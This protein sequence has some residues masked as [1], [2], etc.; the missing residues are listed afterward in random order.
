MDQAAVEPVSI[1]HLTQEAQVEPTEMLAEI[2]PDQT[3]PAV[4]EVAQVP[5][6]QM[7]Q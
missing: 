4:A 2:Q 5:P 7:L 3:I 1:P 6:V